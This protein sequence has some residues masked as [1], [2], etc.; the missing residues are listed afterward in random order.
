MTLCK[1]IGEFENFRGI[2]SDD[3]GKCFTT[4]MCW[5]SPTRL[6]NVITFLHYIALH[7]MDPKPVKMTIGCGICPINTKNICTVSLKPSHKRNQE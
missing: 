2:C 7:S 4:R 3:G 1:L 6:H 5:Y